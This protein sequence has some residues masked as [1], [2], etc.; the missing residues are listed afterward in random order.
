LQQNIRKRNRS[1]EQSIPDGYLF[2]IQETY[3]NYIRQHNIRTIFVDVSNADF[4]GNE[5]HLQVILDA[6]E[7]DLGEGQHYFTLP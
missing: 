7:R 2:N 4:L 1:Y 3:T 5:G 6:L